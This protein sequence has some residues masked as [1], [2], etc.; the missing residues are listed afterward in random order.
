MSDVLLPEDS[1]EN[2]CLCVRSILTKFCSKVFN[3][4]IQ[5]EFVNVQKAKS[6]KNFQNGSHSK[7]LKNNMYSRLFFEYN[8]TK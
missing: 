7:Y 3:R 1:D 2:I 6:L 4:R 5:V 8:C